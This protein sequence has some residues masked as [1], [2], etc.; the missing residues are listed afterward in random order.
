MFPVNDSEPSG[1]FP[2]ATYGI[3]LACIG[4]FAL[5]FFAADTEK[6]VMEWALVPSSVNLSDWRSLIPFVTSMFL[7]G[8]FA[9]IFSNL[10]FFRIFGDNV[11]ADLGFF[12]FV[13]FYLAGGII[14]AIAEYMGMRGASIPVLGASGAIAAVMGYYVVRFP[15]HMISM[16]NGG[17]VSALFTGIMWFASQ[18][19]SGWG[20]IVSS[21]AS[22]GGIAYAAHIAG[23]CFG[24]LSAYAV[25]ALRRKEIR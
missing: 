1:I 24:A 6:F 8:G 20:Q 15:D 2:V 5:Q 23:F 12:G 14:A 10:W 16:I 9:H 17:E 3:I 21:S 4:V 13:L 19:L 25:S 7:H 22:K 18:L 11:E